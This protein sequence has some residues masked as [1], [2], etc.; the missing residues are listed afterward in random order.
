MR[1]EKYRGG[2]M[3]IE[4]AMI[5]P[6]VLGIVILVMRIWFF[7]YD[8]VL[9]DMDTCAV[10]VRCMEQQDMDADERA[11]YVTEQMQGRYK[12]QYIVWNFGDISVSCTG[13]SV[14]CTVT[15]N[16]GHIA[17]ISGLWDVPDTLSATSERK[18]T[19]LPETF[20]IR[21]YRKALGAGE[22]ISSSLNEE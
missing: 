17:G 2:Y 21:T 5:M 7:R 9:Q 11:S 4:A 1:P 6:V 22:Y 3:T 20:V 16:S 10:T 12:D 19:I 18:R 15:G 13:D 14:A 8:R